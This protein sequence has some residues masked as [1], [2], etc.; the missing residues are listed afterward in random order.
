LSACV[1]HGRKFCENEHQSKWKDSLP[2]QILVLDDGTDGDSEIEGI[3]V[4]QYV[5]K[6]VGKKAS[7]CTENLQVANTD[8][9]PI[10]LY[11]PFLRIH[12]I[13]I[14]FKIC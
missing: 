12:I 10:G 13:F 11:I 5:N 8:D 3:V 4:K 9:K 14:S 2:K 1:E 6:A 7:Q